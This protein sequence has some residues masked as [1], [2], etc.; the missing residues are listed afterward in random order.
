MAKSISLDT[1][2]ITSGGG[3]VTIPVSYK[4]DAIIIYSTGTVTLGAAYTVTHSGTPVLGTKITVLYKG[5]ATLTT[6]T[7]TG[8]HISL[9]GT[10]LSDQKANVD[11]EIDFYWNGAAWEALLKPDFSSAKAPVIESSLIVDSA[12]VSRAINDTA[13][14][15]AKI[16]AVSEGNIVIGDSSSRPALLSIKT[17]KAILVGNG[18]TAVPRVLS[19][20]VTMSNTGVVT[21]EDGVITEDK[22]A[23]TLGDIL[24]DEFE[25]SS[26]QILALNSTPITVVPA[27]GA[28]TLIIPLEFWIFLDYD[29]ATYAN[30]GAVHLRIGTVSVGNVAATAVTSASDLVTKFVLTT[31]VA[32]GSLLN[33]D[34]VVDC[35]TADF[36]TGDSPLKCKLL[37]K[38]VSFA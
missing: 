16:Q 23:F 21:I 19:G 15:L 3:S 13:V 31:A 18:T 38:V 2:T 22:L 5:N 11:L 27:Q 29:S 36:I 4:E 37:Y 32:S 30:G 20:D 35:A 1:Y 10:I 34:L 26:A 6:D 8:K 25:I 24:Y 12:I 9:F 7:L 17:D 14:T 28:N 33:Q